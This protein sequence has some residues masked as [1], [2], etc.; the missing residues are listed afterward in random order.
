M[1]ELS[2]YMPPE[3]EKLAER[4]R[5]VATLVYSRGA[6]TAKQVQAQLSPQISN[7]AVRSMLVRLV[8]K[9]VLRRHH[10]RRGRGQEFVY[11]PRIT[12]THVKVVT[13]KTLADQHFDGS[14]F[15]LA[16]MALE[17]NALR[18]DDSE[19]QAASEPGRLLSQVA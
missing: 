18:T 8:A 1:Q 5:Q 7:G 15:H 10:G 11:V 9:G 16:V 19:E 4:E 6:C 12:P 3:V 13:L 14:L 17:L 2:S